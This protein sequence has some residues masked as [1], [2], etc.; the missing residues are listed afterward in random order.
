LLAPNIPA[1]GSIARENVRNFDL[2][3]VREHRR[4]LVNPPIPSDI[5]EILRNESRFIRFFMCI[6]FLPPGE[7]AAVQRSPRVVD[8]VRP[9]WEI[10]SGAPN[11]PASAAISRAGI[12]L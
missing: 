11:I 4:K 3:L 9:Q 6:P 2:H 12:K 10:P 5:P 8:S 7:V 1:S